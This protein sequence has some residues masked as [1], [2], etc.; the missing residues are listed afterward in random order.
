MRID[1]VI[2][3]IEYWTENRGSLKFYIDGM[4][5]KVNNIEQR[6]EMGYPAKSPR[7]AIAYKF[8]AER[9]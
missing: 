1:E 8:T 5:V 3:F 9:K 2:E 6:N 4:F 7:C